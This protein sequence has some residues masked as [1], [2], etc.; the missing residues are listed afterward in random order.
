M[1]GE[2]HTQHPSWTVCGKNET[3]DNKKKFLFFKMILKEFT[4]PST[5][6]LCSVYEVVPQYLEMF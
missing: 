3:M 5:E 4:A 2:M 1:D 6:S